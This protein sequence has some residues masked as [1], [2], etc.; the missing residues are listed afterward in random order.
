M[1]GW[2]DL[3]DDAGEME[4]VLAARDESGDEDYD[5]VLSRIYVETSGLSPGQKTG[6]VCECVC[7]CAE[8]LIVRNQQAGIQICALANTV[9]A[10]EVMSLSYVLPQ[11]SD[12][13]EACVALFY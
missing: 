12:R 7:V 13:Y 3:N 6:C 9:D 10:V 8:Q 4:A 1:A 5:E 11:L 2:S